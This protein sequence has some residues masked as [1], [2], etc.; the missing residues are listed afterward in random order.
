MKKEKEMLPVAKSKKTGP[1]SDPV[2]KFKKGKPTTAAAIDNIITGAVKKV[3][4]SSGKGF[5]NEGTVPF[6]GEES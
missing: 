5:A 4:P 2:N 6:Y 1:G 3:K